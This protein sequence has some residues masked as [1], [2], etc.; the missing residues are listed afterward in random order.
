MTTPDPRLRILEKIAIDAGNRAVRVQT[1]S[2]ISSKGG[3]DIVTN[4]DL[5]SQAIILD[6]L[7]TSFPEIPVVTEESDT[8]IL[9]HDIFFAVDPIDGTRNYSVR[10]SD[11]G[12]SI[13]LIENGA[14]I[15]GMIYHP[16]RSLLLAGGPKSPT[17]INTTPAKLNPKRQLK[18]SMIAVEVTWNTTKEDMD[19]YF[20]IGKNSCGIRNLLAATANTTDVLLGVTGAY[21]SRRIG[22]IWDFAA[23]AALIAGAGGIA[24]SPSGAPLDWRSVPMDVL[25]SASSTIHDEILSRIKAK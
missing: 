22:K 10:G 2:V 15:L 7:R 11:W 16:V 8:H 5:E 12:V 17:T 4:G 1:S 19:D 6:R 21:L 3:F 18:D 14:P 23:G 13:A 25:F 24:S 9:T 20:A